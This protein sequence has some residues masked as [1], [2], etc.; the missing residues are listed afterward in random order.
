MNVLN[1]V[2]LASQTILQPTVIWTVHNPSIKHTCTADSS[3]TKLAI[4]TAFIMSIHVHDNTQFAVFAYNTLMHVYNNTTY[5][6]GSQ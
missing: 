4:S 5:P 3:C 2:S 1:S 6:I